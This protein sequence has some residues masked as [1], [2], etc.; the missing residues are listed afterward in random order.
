MILARRVFGRILAA[1]NSTAVSGQR[2]DSG[3][4][5][6]FAALMMSAL[7]GVLALAID[8]SYMYA[9]R[10]QLAAGLSGRVF[11]RPIQ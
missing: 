3:S 9:Q 7:I 1:E 2:N 4:I 10:N 5:L 6:I 8:G 11:L